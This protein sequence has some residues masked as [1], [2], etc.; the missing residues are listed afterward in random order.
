[1]EDE[2]TETDRS[3]AETLSKSIGFRRID[4]VLDHPQKVYYSGHQISGNVHLELDEPTNALGIR[5]KCK[6][7]AQVYFTDRSAGIRRKF[8]AFENY[9]H[10]ETYVVGDG[11]EKSVITGGVYPFSLTLPEKLPCSFEGRYGRVRYSI[12]ALLD[13]T[14]IYR[15]STNIIPF[16]VAP[17]LDLNRDPLAPLLIN[18]KQSKMY[19]GQTEPLTV[20]MSLPVRGYVPGQ[21]IP[22]TI[23]MTNLSTVVVTKIRIVFKK[24]E[25]CVDVSEWYYRMFQ[26][27]LKLRTNIV[28]GTVPLQNYET[29]QKTTDVTEDFSPHPQCTTEEYA[30]DTQP[31]KNSERVERGRSSLSLPLYE[32]SQIYRSS[33]PDKDDPTGDDGDSDGEVKPYSP[34]YRVYKFKSSLKKAR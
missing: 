23:L 7:E 21:A 30:D 12:R 29:P 22:I 4:I 5:L 9:L 18:I 8:S 14:T 11:K 17:I 6:G 31:L 16:T 25:A 32:K 3:I 20:S 15:F 34:M 27:N 1:M 28:V 10:V 24:V 19:I 13:V 33:K 26:K 2:E